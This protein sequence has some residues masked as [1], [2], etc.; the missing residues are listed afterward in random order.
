MIIDWPFFFFWPFLFWTANGTAAAHH[1]ARDWVCRRVVCACVTSLV[2]LHQVWQ[3]ASRHCVK[4]PARGAVT[5]A[6]PTPRLDDDHSPRA[7]HHWNTLCISPTAGACAPAAK[8]GL[9]LQNGAAHSRSLE[10][11]QNIA[12]VDMQA[13]STPI[14]ALQVRGLAVDVAS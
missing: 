3:P 8:L 11:C 9:A 6:A 13:T 14:V 4:T 2:L 1:A 5:N 12:Q 7:T 10:P